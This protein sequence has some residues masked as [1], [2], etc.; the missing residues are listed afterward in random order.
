[1][2][3]ADQLVE[4][5]SIVEWMGRAMRPLYLSEI[6]SAIGLLSPSRKDE[7][8]LGQRVLDQYNNI[9]KLVRDD[10]VS[11]EIID[12]QPPS[13]LEQP[14]QFLPATTRVEFIQPGTKN[15]FRDHKAKMAEKSLFRTPSKHIMHILDSGFTIHESCLRVLTSPQAAIKLGHSDYAKGFWCHHLVHAYGS[16]GRWGNEAE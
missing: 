13:R 10:G 6:C 1:M 3:Q 2:L 14:F 5:D 9:L 12:D 16:L 4:I 7:E 8:A 15:Y 11:S